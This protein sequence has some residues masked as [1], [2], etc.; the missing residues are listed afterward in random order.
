MKVLKVGVALLVLGTV[1]D[2]AFHAV[3]EPEEAFD[4][5]LPPF[6]LADHFAIALGVGV[7]AIGLLLYLIRR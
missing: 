1:A 3:T 6:E 4:L 5:S 2:L 7:S